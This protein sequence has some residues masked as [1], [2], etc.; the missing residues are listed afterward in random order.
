MPNGCSI[1]GG[2]LE[3]AVIVAESMAVGLPRVCGTHRS[4]VRATRTMKMIQ[5]RPAI[6][7]LLRLRRFQASLQRVRDAAPDLTSFS[8]DLALSFS[9]K[10]CSGVVLF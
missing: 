7:S 4:A 2:S 3:L 5:M 10:D 8:A 9:S 1:D 6:A